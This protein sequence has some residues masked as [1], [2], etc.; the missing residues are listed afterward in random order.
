MYDLV[1]SLAFPPL[2]PDPCAAA[3][4]SEMAKAVATRIRG[5]RPAGCGSSACSSPSTGS[6]LSSTTLEYGDLGSAPSMIECVRCGEDIVLSPAGEVP[7]GAVYSGKLEQKGRCA[8]CNKIGAKMQYHGISQLTM[9]DDDSRKRFWIEA[10]GLSGA[11]LNEYT[12]RFLEIKDESSQG[13]GCRSKFM[14]LKYYTDKGFDGEKI[15]QTTPP[16][17]IM[18]T[19]LATL[20]RIDIA[21]LEEQ[22]RRVKTEGEKNYSS[23]TKRK[24]WF[25]P[26]K[27]TKSAKSAD[28][29]NWTP[30]Q[31]DQ[32]K[33]SVGKDLDKVIQAVEKNVKK[34]P[35]AFQTCPEAIQADCADLLS[36]IGKFRVEVAAL[37]AGKITVDQVKTPKS[38]ASREKVL[39][40]KATK[41][42]KFY[43]SFDKAVLAVAQTVAESPPR[44][45]KAKAKAKASAKSKAKGKAKAKAS[46]KHT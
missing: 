9:P 5:K 33:E 39:T 20:Y 11:R 43:A 7:K 14:P 26:M 31:V 37:E 35:A 42:Y 6:G 18:E 19:E 10:R 34:N 25:A 28:P 40:K 13:H 8:E 3:A 16:E 17:Q 41:F 15:L 32:W 21:F 38:F 22:E 44:N 2:L 24:Q 23:P 29:A 30:E 46:K 45:G 27:A 4:E 1:S 12:R 36:D